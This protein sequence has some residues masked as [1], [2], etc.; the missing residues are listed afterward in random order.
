MRHRALC[1]RDPCRQGPASVVE[2]R[3]K[4]ISRGEAVWEWWL[5]LKVLGGA[6]RVA[7]VIVIVVVVVV[8]VCHERGPSGL[9][10]HAN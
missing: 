10:A 1:S 6:D 5:V 4:Q 8:V 7:V 2:F 3:R 9:L